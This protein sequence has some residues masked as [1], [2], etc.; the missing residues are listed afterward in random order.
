MTIP[1]DNDQRECGNGDAL[2]EHAP[3]GP[4]L[5]GDTLDAEVVY[6]GPIVAPVKAGDELAELILR[7]EGLPET[8]VPL[9]AAADVAKGG[10]L[11][12]LRTASQ[13]LMERFAGAPAPAPA[14]EARP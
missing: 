11:V 14:A 10:F 7:P 13:H 8:R 6:N 9:V 5:V 12:K 4:V 1:P 3:A 2:D